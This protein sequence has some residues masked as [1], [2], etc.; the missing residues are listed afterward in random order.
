MSDDELDLDAKAFGELAE[1]YQEAVD[2]SDSAAA[3]EAMG[4]I[5]SLAAE[6]CESNPSEDFNL[7]VAAH[8]CEERAD[9][10]GAEAAHKQILSLE[11]ADEIVRGKAC[12]D[13]AGLCSLLGRD[14]EALDYARQATVLVR[15]VDVP[16]LLALFLTG[17]AR[18]LIECGRYEE[19]EAIVD[20]GLKLAADEDMQSQVYPNFLTLRAELSLHRKNLL[21]ADRDLAAAFDGHS[22]YANMEMAAGVKTDLMRW[23]SVTAK[24][25]AARSDLSGAVVACETAVATAREVTAMPHAESVYAHAALARRLEELGDALIADGR[26]DDAA[27]AFSESRAIFERIGLAGYRTDLA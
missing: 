18:R 13:L 11:T 4:E 16:V 21:E 22:R 5:F 24:L 27:A 7:T 23:W 6:W 17:E 9:W 20:E 12:S 3:E 19:L 8:E 14:E 10:V 15:R 25:R 2:A 1:R 26:E